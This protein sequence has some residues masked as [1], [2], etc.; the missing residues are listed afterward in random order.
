MLKFFACAAAGL[1][2]VAAAFTASAQDKGAQ[3]GDIAERLVAC[4]VAMF[5]DSRPDFSATRMYAVRQ[6]GEPAELLLGPDFIGPNRWYSEDLQLGFHR[7]N[8]RGVVSY[9]DLN[10]AYDRVGY[11]VLRQ[12]SSRQSRNWQP[13][14]EIRQQARECGR[15]ARDARLGRLED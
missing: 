1:T 12:Y 3:P 15:L 6:T 4:D 10:S 7:L 11:P 9:D 8:A 5:L 13:S 2:L 14:P